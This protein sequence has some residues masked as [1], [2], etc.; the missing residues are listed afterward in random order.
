MKTNLISI[1]AVLFF[2]GGCTTVEFVRKDTTP[3]KKAVLR[4]TPPSDEKKAAKYKD[5]VNKK[6][7]EFCGGDFNVTK[8]YQARQ[9]TGSSTGLGTGVGLGMGGIMLGT[10]HQSSVMYNFV[11]L[12]C[13]Q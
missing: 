3:E 2:L 9:P 5:E 10:S 1:L 8:E 12:S 7:H 4:H 13:A 11:E 6:A